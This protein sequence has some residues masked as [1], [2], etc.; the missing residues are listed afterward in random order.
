MISYELSYPISM[1]IIEKEFTYIKEGEK[2]KWTIFFLL[3]IVENV[4]SCAEGHY[5]FADNCAINVQEDD[6]L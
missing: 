5:C 6:E 4:C 1:Q 3:K 2:K